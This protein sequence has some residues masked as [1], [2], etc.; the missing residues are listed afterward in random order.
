MGI[1]PNGAFKKKHLLLKKL[2]DITYLDQDVIKN[3]LGAVLTL[4]NA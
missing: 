4:E 1:S 2:L 3:A